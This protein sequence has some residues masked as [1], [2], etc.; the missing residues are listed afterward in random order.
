MMKRLA[1]AAMSTA[2]VTAPA[3]ANQLKEY[4]YS[5]PVLAVVHESGTQIK[6]KDERCNQVFGSYNMQ[7]D[8]MVICIEKHDS[9]E[10]LG[11]TIRH[12]AIHVIQS[13]NAGPVLG[14][15]QTVQYAKEK[16]ITVTSEYPTAHQHM[17]LEARIAA[18]NLDD[19][20]VAS[21]VRKFCFE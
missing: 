13:C 2:V 10:E 14:L 16:D 1:I 21:L 6:F 5:N 8:I 18:R 12:E 9:Y 7:T 4:I 3:Q 19:N 20:Q 17:E 11:D 15:F